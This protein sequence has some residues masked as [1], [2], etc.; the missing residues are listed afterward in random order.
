VGVSART[1]SVSELATAVEMVSS[2]ALARVP[3][4]GN[5]HFSLECMHLLLYGPAGYTTLCL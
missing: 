2:G 4:G 5:S 3:T 1:E